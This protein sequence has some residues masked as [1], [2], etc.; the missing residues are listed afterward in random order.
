MLERDAY[1][2]WGT[3]Y[4]G[5]PGTP[6]GWE[7]EWGVH[8]DAET[9]L[10]LMGKRY[11][12]PNLGRFLSRDPAGFASGP[13]VYAFC[14]DDPIDLMDPSGELPGWM[15]NSYNWWLNGMGGA[16]EVT[17]EYVMGGLTRQ[18]GETAGRYDVGKASAAEVAWT[19]TKWGFWLGATALSVFTP[20]VG[21]EAAEAKS[22]WQLG[23]EGGEA[24][25]WS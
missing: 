18:F 3:P 21:A 10:V 9:G 17:D 8:R 2:A 25:I 22:A 1:T 19:G 5:A 20:K 13:N 12:A 7:G 11:Y 15:V 24:T 4:A 23:Q 16:S 6:F 14:L